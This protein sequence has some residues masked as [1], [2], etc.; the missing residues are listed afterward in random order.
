MIPPNVPSIRIPDNIKLIIF[1]CDGVL[2][3]SEV[4]SQRVLLRMLKALNVDVSPDYFNTNFL[5][6]SFDHVKQK[7]L[8]DYLVTLPNN[9]SEHY[10]HALLNEFTTELTPTDQLNWM[11]KQ[12]PIP[13]CVA[14]SSSPQRAHRA[15]AITQL[16]P[17]FSHCVFTASEVK[18]GKPAPDLFLHAAEK[19]HVQPEHCLVIEDSPTGIQAA[20]AA[21]MHI[22]HYAGASHLQHPTANTFNGVTTITHWR[23][24][25]ELAP[26][27]SST[28]KT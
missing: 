20:Q 12:L 17:Y 6:Y 9:F 26:W 2:I 21:N 7:I 13:Y 1:D 22:I 27:L 10:Q 11:L 8:D 24:L 15:L 19:M 25:F 23:Q 14:T 4:I 18:K 5:G 3:D 16:A 28:F